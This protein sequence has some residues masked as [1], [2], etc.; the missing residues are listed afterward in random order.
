MSEF[1]DDIRNVI[2]RH[3]KEGGS[4]TPDFILAK[5]LEDCLDAF[6]F[7]LTKR[8]AWLSVEKYPFGETPEVVRDLDDSNLT[9]E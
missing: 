6:D 5:F 2:N 1:K 3:S 9:D 7:A 8:S 4:N